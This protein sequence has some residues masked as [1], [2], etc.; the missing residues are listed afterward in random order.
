M[1]IAAATRT[2][3]EWWFP[4]DHQTFHPGRHINARTMALVGC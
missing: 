3:L 4:A 2:A 1:T